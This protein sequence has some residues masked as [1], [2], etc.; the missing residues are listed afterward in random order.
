MHDC[1]FGAEGALER[2]RLINYAQ[3]IGLDV[4]RFTDDL[5]SRRFQDAVNQDF[6]LAVS[7]KIKLPPQL[8]INS[9]SLEG[10]RTKDAI[11]DRIEN[12]LACTSVQS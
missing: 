2:E 12:L 8:F 11:C 1:L 10:P 7:R 6:K 5:D 9:L 4:E 3:E